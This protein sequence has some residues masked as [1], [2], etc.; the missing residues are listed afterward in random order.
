MVTNSVP[1]QHLTKFGV[2]FRS[3]L[4]L[5]VC[6][7]KIKKRIVSPSAS[8][9][10]QWKFIHRMHFSFSIIICCMYYKQHSYTETY[11]HRPF[12]RASQEQPGPEHHYTQSKRIF[13][14]VR[15]IALKFSTHKHIHSDDWMHWQ[16]DRAHRI[17]KIIIMRMA[18]VIVGTEQEQQKQTTIQAKYNI[19]R[20]GVELHLHLHLIK[21]VCS[22]WFD[23]NQM[24]S[25]LVF[26]R[27]NSDY[28]CIPSKGK[29]KSNLLNEIVA[30][31]PFITLY[32]YLMQWGFTVDWLEFFGILSLVLYRYGPIIYNE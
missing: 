17:A 16:A 30:F 21:M 3:I 20:L 10:L 29:V 28:V 8:Q 18:I 6:Y 27:F 4:L 22:E 24:I 9:H 2:C 5:C 32:S 23:W 31:F 12:S 19:R 14:R 13:I 25:F 7:E 15:S 26:F 11:I 1:L